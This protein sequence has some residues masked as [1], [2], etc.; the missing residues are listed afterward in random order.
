MRGPHIRAWL[1]RAGVAARVIAGA[2]ALATAPA[3]GA[4]DSPSGP[5]F[6]RLDGPASLAGTWRFRVGDDPAFAAPS[7]ADA[8]WSRIRVPGPW[9]RQGHRGHAGFAWYRLTL[10]L[11]EAAAASARAGVLGVRLGNVDSSYV[12]YAG[13]EAIGGVG[14][15]PPAPRLMYDR[16]A[17]FALPARAVDGDGR[18]VLALRVWRAPV[19]REFQGGITSGPVTI[20]P[21]AA[22][23]RDLLLR[24]IATVALVVL[25]TLAAF[26]H[27]YLFWRRRSLREYLW[28]GASSLLFAAYTFLRS[29]I[30][31][32]LSEDFELLKKLEYVALYAI[33]IPGS[34]SS[35]RSSRAGRRR[36][37]GSARS[38]PARW[39]S[40]SRSRR[41]SASASRRSRSGSCARPASRRASSCS[42]RA[43]CAAVIPRRA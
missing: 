16:H 4:E 9:G 13:G 17:V 1:G 34:S 25:F 10:T 5:H 32:G 36:S 33:P 15:L 3:A 30:K 39:R 37:C 6:A 24:E 14:G 42:S 23:Q 26:Y 12:L 2:L 43:S 27:L 20:G 8:D 28:F 21:L 29:Q 7:F 41:A 19:T 40:A 35:R 38:C 31:Y 11:G 18:V 22:L